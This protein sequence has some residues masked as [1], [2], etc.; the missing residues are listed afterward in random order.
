MKADLGLD[1]PAANAPPGP[2]TLT[3]WKNRAIYRVDDAHIG[4]WSAEAAV[5]LGGA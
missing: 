2:A 5:N 4:G 3:R 1:G